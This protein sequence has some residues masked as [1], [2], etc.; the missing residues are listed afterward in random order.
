MQKRIYLL[1]SALWLFSTAYSQNF[2]FTLQGTLP[3]PNDALSNIWGWWDGVGNEYA[4]VGTES[5]LSIVDVTNPQTPV[6]LFLI[7]GPN[8]IWREVRTH[9]HYAY[10]TTEGGG[11]VTIIDLSQLP[12]AAPYTQYTGD[13]AIN[14]QLDN[15]HS[16]HIDGG[17]LYLHGSNLFNGTTVICDLNADP[18]NP[19]YLSN[20]G[21]TYVHDGM[22]RGNFY[23]PCHIY[24][25]EF[26]IVD[27]TDKSNPVTLN[28][29]ITPGQFTHNSWLSTNSQVLFSTDEVQNSFLTSYDVS[30]PNNITE[31][32]RMQVT[33]GSQSIIHNTYVI[34][35]NGTDY[36]VSSWYKDGTAIADVARPDNM[37]FIGWFDTYVQG[38]G[39][40]FNGAWGVYMYLPSGNVLVS[41]IDNGLYVLTPNYV[42][43]CYLEGTVTDSVTGLP[44]NNALVEILNTSISKNSK[45]NGEYKTGYYQ[46]G[47]YDVRYSRSGYVTKTITGVSLTNGVVTNLDVELSP[48]GMSVTL[49]GQVIDNANGNPVPN[50]SVNFVSSSFS[51]NTT[52]DA[53]GNF[54]IPGFFV[55]NYDYVAG[56]WGYIN[57]CGNITI[58][59]GGGTNTI[60]LDKGYYDDFALD[61]GW[62]NTGAA[63]DWVRGEPIGTTTN[64]GNPANPD[65]DSNNDCLDQAY[66]TG[67]GTGGVAD[68]DVDPNDGVVTLTSP[69]FDLTTYINPI[70][71]YERWF[72]NAAL[73]GNQP[74]DEMNIKL[75]NG[76]TTVTLEQLV[77]NS[78]GNGT[79]VAS[80]FAV[81][82]FITPTANMQLIAET[83]DNA[84][85]SIV[86][87]GFDKFEVIEGP[88]SVA[89]VKDQIASVNASPNPFENH[90]AVNYSLLS[91]DY[92]NAF[93]RISDVTGKEL[94]KENL[95]SRA[96]T[97]IVNRKMD[98]G[99][100]FINVLT[101]EGI[102]TTLK[103]VKTK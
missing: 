67:N 42:R 76:I 75:T 52:S 87:G 74:N 35:K 77:P 1:L 102:S 7:P 78:V 27:V 100:Y 18:W 40:G 94:V 2:N 33:P 92:S 101:K 38:A 68:H 81:S 65:F 44:I 82:Q 3:Y 50:A 86:E 97:L 56:A 13:G 17:Y 45:I 79:W 43:A 9:D 14:G 28:S 25:G 93:I 70:I 84:P 20:V 47:S 55:G 71:N 95:T 103:I 69:V 54:S 62:T 57:D 26:S 63:N 91:N 5:G 98:N 31:L 10:V 29:Q 12:T 59:A 34:E 73:N 6:E 51:Y 46:A 96:G 39:G 41:D 37:V 66:V 90:I 36:A 24:Q 21:T 8:S 99:V 61:F 53:V 88:A 11:G 23:Y 60:S 85:R 58:N 32:D 80:S 64:G 15:I 19:V 49:N 16:L 48:I 30:N 83:F 22:A 4:L 89:Q 72:V